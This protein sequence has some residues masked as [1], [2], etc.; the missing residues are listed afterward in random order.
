MMGS[1]LRG[2][3]NLLIYVGLALACATPFALAQP[4]NADKKPNPFTRLFQ[5]IRDRL[6]Q[7][8]TA[9]LETSTQRI[10]FL[11]SM[12]ARHPNLITSN[13]QF[14]RSLLETLNPVSALNT[15][16]AENAND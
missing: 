3:R 9:G 11:Q 14:R 6:P 13:L 5:A 10:R 7:P 8:E 15:G 16:L 1:L 12:L 2:L 4:T